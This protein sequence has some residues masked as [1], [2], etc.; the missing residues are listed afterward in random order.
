MDLKEFSKIVK[1]IINESISE[2]TAEFIKKLHE[3]TTNYNFGFMILDNKSVKI[4][5]P[6]RSL[7]V[8]FE[9]ANRMLPQKDYTLS[10]RIFSD[11]KTKTI[12]K[13]AHS[14]INVDTL[15][16]E[17]LLGTNADR[18]FY[19]IVTANDFEIT[20][21]EYEGTIVRFNE[22]KQAEKF[23]QLITGL[24]PFVEVNKENKKV[25]VYCSFEI[26]KYD[27]YSKDI[28][29]KGKLKCTIKIDGSPAGTKLGSFVF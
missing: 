1:E 20:Y 3:G 17:L 4:M 9:I 19:E 26:E 27:G 22:E 28:Q 11:G 8:A 7:P 23:L 25:E 29:K 10:L 6:L 5:S 14:S 13:S 21:S 2:N 15:K 16:K 18:I 24:F 12:S